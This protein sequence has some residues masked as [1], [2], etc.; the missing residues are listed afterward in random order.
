[1]DKKKAIEILV[2]CGALYQQNLAN[3]NYLIL[4]G[5]S[6]RPEQMELRFL[7]QNFKHL[8]GVVLRSDISNNQFYKKC[9]NRKLKESD[10][11]FSADGTT[12]LKLSV[13]PLLFNLHKNVKMVS[14]YDHSKVKLETDTLTGGQ[15]GCLGFI[16]EQVYCAPNTALKEDIRSISTETPKRII[17]MLRKILAI[18]HMRTW[19]M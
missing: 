9:V 16:M 5:D 8:T 6:I 7:P 1:M 18:Q 17:A 14:K 2:Q 10:F 3:Q 4:Y 13:L 15:H 19:S 12:P 11:S